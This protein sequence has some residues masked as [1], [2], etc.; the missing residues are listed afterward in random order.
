MALFYLLLNRGAA[1]EVAANF[2]L[3]PGLV[4][5]LGWSLLGEA[6][7]PL[8]LVGFAVASAGVFLVARR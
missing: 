5:F 8:A 6:L 3:I 2:Y 4:A 7:A 1:G